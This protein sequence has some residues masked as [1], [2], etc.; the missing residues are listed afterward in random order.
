MA[1]NR[2]LAGERISRA[3][4]DAAGTPAEAAIEAALAALDCEQAATLAL[5]RARTAT[6]PANLVGRI[7]PGIELPVITCALV[8]ISPD[9]GRC[10]SRSSGGGSRRPRMPPSSRRSCST[11]AW[12]AGAAVDRI[13]PELRRLAARSM[14]AEGY[15]LLATIAASIDDANVK[16]ACKPIA[17]FATEYKK[18]VAQDDAAMHASIDKV[19]AALPAEVETSLGGF[20]VRG[21]KQ[22]GRNDPCS[23]GS[24]PQVQEVLRRQAGPRRH[25]RFPASP[26]DDFFAVGQDAAP[27]H[28]TQLRAKGPRAD[29]HRE[30][31]AIA[32]LRAL[33][34][35]FVALRAPW[36]RVERVVAEQIARA[37][38]P[39]EPRK[40]RDDLVFQLL[41]AG[42][43]ERAR[44]HIAA[45]GEHPIYAAELAIR[46][47]KDPWPALL[48]AV[49]AFV[50]SPI[51][52]DDADLAYALLRA[53]PTLGIYFA[54]ACIGTLHVD[55]ADLMLEYV[56]DARDRLGL[57]PTD[58]AWDILD[59][60]RAGVKSRA[61]R[62]PGK[63][64]GDRGHGAARCARTDRAARADDRRPC[65]PSSPTCAR[66][67]PP[68]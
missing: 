22:P 14:T 21:A 63:G 30:G 45:L 2:V 11:S 33:H 1:E 53:E 3:Q 66:A 54:R 7:L 61:R 23:C 32:A 31:R 64:S 57:S 37:S 8:A 6:V 50:D 36:D 38:D 62:A 26:W 39:D 52:A 12:K 59:T 4:L 20:T 34:T 13:K 18:Q 47:G 68:S 19:V 49:R 41:E 10:S 25:R 28:V 67:P 44:P 65:A 48:A 51:N 16:A 40:L 43:I 5:A 24:G 15:A 29:R 35:R 56:E 46:D 60:L 42:E 9:R 17:S 55:D 58:P 27:E